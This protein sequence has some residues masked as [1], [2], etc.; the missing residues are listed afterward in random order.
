MLSSRMYLSP[1]LPLFLGLPLSFPPN[2]EC[3]RPWAVN[4]VHN[5][6]RVVSPPICFGRLGA[7]YETT[8]THISRTC[9]VS[10][11]CIAT[12][13]R[14]VSCDSRGAHRHAFY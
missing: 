2:N 6:F 9:P 7:Q 14:A 10:V 12:G 1:A 4:L 8:F 13:S 11:V 5:C 3:K